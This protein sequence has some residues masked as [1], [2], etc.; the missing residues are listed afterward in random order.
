M[1]RWPFLKTK[2]GIALIVVMILI[3]LSGLA[4]LAALPKRGGSGSVAVAQDIISND[5]YFYG[6]SPPVYPSRECFLGLDRGARWAKI[7]Y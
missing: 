6:Q 3:L 4:G 2:R 5:T 1:Q 7:E